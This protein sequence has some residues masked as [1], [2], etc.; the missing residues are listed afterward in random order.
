[1]K[2]GERR[3]DRPR[4]NTVCS[5]Y[6]DDYL[7]HTRPHWIPTCFTLHDWLDAEEHTLLLDDYRSHWLSHNDTL[8]YTL[9]IMYTLDRLYHNRAEAINQHID[10]QYDIDQHW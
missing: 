2:Q 10:S 1:M 7:A 8:S 3:R 9:D 4:L 6:M 5:K